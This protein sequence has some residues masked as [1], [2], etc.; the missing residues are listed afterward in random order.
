M[1]GI[2]L[3][4]YPSLYTC[5]EIDDNFEIYN[6]ETKQYKLWKDMKKLYPD[7]IFT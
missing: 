2:F 4:N 1:N 7:W 5:D 6:Q 3:N